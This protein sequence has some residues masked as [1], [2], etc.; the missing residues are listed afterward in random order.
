MQYILM[1]QYIMSCTHVSANRLLKLY[2]NKNIRK[3][4]ELI[5]LN[6]IRK[7]NLWDKLFSLTFIVRLYLSPEEKH[8]IWLLEIIAW[9]DC[10]IHL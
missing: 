4:V 9:T 8:R 6:V 7:I 10:E 1:M 3:Y 5:D 2:W